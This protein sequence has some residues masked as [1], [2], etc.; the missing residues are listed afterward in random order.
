M[1]YQLDL[2]KSYLLQF[3]YGKHFLDIDKPIIVGPDISN[4]GS[5]FSLMCSASANPPATYQWMKNNVVI[6]N[7]ISMNYT[8]ITNRSDIA[9]Y[10]CRVMNV[11]GTMDSDPH[12]LKVP[13]KL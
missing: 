9:N 10:T 13:C 7:A 2:K 5:E 1:N 4:E 3:I 6:N 11:L 12:E 8:K